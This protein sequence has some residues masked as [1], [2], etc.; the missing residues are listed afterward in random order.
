MAITV[1]RKIRAL[2]VP[3]VL[4]GLFARHG[5]PERGRPGAAPWTIAF[6]TAR[7]SCPGSERGTGPAGLVRRSLFRTTN[8]VGPSGCRPWNPSIALGSVRYAGPHCWAG[9]T[10]MIMI[11]VLPRPCDH[12]NLERAA[13]PS[14][15]GG[16]RRTNPSGTRTG[17]ISAC[18]RCRPSHA[19]E[20]GPDHEPGDSLDR[21]VALACELHVGCQRAQV[22]SLEPR[23]ASPA[24]KQPVARPSRTTPR[25]ERPHSCRSSRALHRR[26]VDVPRRGGLASWPSMLSGSDAGPRC[27]RAGA[28]CV[29]DPL[30]RSGRVL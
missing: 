11:L 21:A 13:V 26:P 24:L 25:F 3:E 29:H 28:P 16:L 6:A 2:G 27:L 9:F 1:A 7:R 20:R 15:S 14:E 12:R 22:R 17:M 23:T 30:E 18:M 5:P 10:N 8:D 19:L 4:A